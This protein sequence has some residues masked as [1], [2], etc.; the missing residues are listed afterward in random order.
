MKNQFRKE[1]EKH[2][3]LRYTAASNDASSI[4]TKTSKRNIDRISKKMAKKTI[5]T[6][7]GSRYLRHSLSWVKGLTDQNLGIPYLTFYGCWIER[8]PCPEI[9]VK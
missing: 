1:K 7:N 4:I 3:M 2:V 8:A 5:T 9:G 6:A